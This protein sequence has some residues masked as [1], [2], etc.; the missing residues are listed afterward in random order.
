MK[1]LGTASGRGCD[2]PGFRESPIPGRRRNS[3]PPA[4]NHRLRPTPLVDYAGFHGLPGNAPP[5]KNERYRLFP[6]KLH[7]NCPQPPA[8]ATSMRSTVTTTRARERDAFAR[9]EA[10]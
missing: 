9:N 2:R 1:A 7:E 8:D 5:D 6:A 4:H 3:G 10:P